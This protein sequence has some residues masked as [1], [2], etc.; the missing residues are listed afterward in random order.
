MI[1]D[2]YQ[3]AYNEEIHALSHSL[4]AIVDDAT[5][6]RFFAKWI[7]GI[8]KDSTPGKILLNKLRH[9][10]K[11]ANKCLPQ[12]FDYDWDATHQAYCI[13]YELIDAKSLEDC[14]SQLSPIY[15]FKGM[16]Q[17][18]SSLSQINQNYDLTHGDI[19]P[20]NVLVDE[21]LNFHLLNLGISDI[22]HTLSEE[23]NI[24]MLAAGF[25]APEKT[26]KSISSGS[27]PFQSDIYSIGKVVEW[28][29]KQKEIE[30][31]EDI[32]AFIGCCCATPE[33][34][35]RYFDLLSAL[36]KINLSVS[37]YNADTVY[38]SQASSQF[39]KELNDSEHLP[40]F[41]VSPKKGGNILMNIA[42]K[43]LIVHCMWLVDERKMHVINQKRVAENTSKYEVTNRYGVKLGLPIKFD[44]A[45][46]LK[47]SDQ[48]DLGPELAKLANSNE[49]DTSY[50]SGKRSIKKELSFYKDLLNKEIEILNRNHFK[51]N[52]SSY[53]VID[54][55]ELHLT[56]NN[57]EKYSSNADI[58][59]HIDRA[60]PPQPEE[61][62]YNLSPKADL[63]QVKR[64]VSISGT[65]YDFDPKN[66]ILKIKDIERLEKGS[67]FNNGFLFEDI[68]K[69]L[70]EKTRQLDA[71]KKVENNEVQNRDLIHYLFNPSELK[72]SFLNVDVLDTVCQTD[73]DGKPFSYSHNQQ[74][75]IINALHREPLTV[76]Q[77]PPGTGKTTV[78]TEIVLQILSSKPDAKILI[79]SQTNDA[80]D[81]V[82]DNL[83]TKEV[84]FVRLSGVN[85]PKQSLRKHTLEKKIDGWKTKVRNKTKTKIKLLQEEFNAGLLQEDLFIGKIFS[86][87]QQDT[88]W[89]KRKTEIEQ[90]IS[91]LPKYKELQKHLSSQDEFIVA[92]QAINNYDLESYMKET[93]LLKGWLDA[94]SSID[95]RSIFNQKLIDTIRVIGATTSHI[96]AKKYK[97]YNFSFDYVIMDESGKAKVSEALIPI[98]MTGKLVFVGDHRQLRPMLTSNR[99]VEK[100]LRSKYTEEGYEY[101]SWE[102]YIDKP[103]LFEQ[104]I[105]VI[106]DDFK[107]QLDVCRRSSAEQIKLTSECF[108]EPYGDEAIRSEERPQVAEHN[109]E[110]NIEGT[111]FFI[112]IGSEYKSRK[113]G[114][115]S[116]FNDQ[117]AEVVKEILSYLDDQERVKGYSVGVITPYKAQVKRINRK[118][119]KLKNMSKGAGLI[120]SVVDKFQGLEKDI[121]IVDLVRSGEKTLGFLSKDNRINVA[122]S[123]QKK[124][125][126]IVG[127]YNGLMNAAKPGKQV[128]ESKPTGL[129]LYLR[130]LPERAILRTPKELFN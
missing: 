11:A 54:D 1:L 68:S 110:L 79:T 124:L 37:F 99:E 111:V 101:D 4:Q 58:A 123:R 102:D 100:W 109:L 126:I 36:K 51:L 87:S 9:H 57:N 91:R 41:N 129:Q 52:Y 17:I 89:E 6:K 73:A 25:A 80:V 67:I 84:P 120:I 130:S 69:E 44:S 12:L 93:E 48:F 14:L 18:A 29:F 88:T 22:V 21:D 28:F 38:I 92:L 50:L 105:E 31:T 23:S 82:L 75:A 60:T 64:P 15:F 107:S 16:E 19:N 94:I 39:I 61:F 47:S 26:N 106:D 72:G 63:K 127:D 45:I 116:S 71:L 74:R 122:F 59:S 7:K 53:Q 90:F 49:K 113:E 117:S 128:D 66:R 70:Q 125:L 32:A 2:K 114:G 119:P 10:K 97:D 46:S 56:I 108:Y 27:F 121:V 76:I 115:G 83:L 8:R 43:S 77:G 42:T 35:Y 86:I 95:D 65:V 40:V 30:V 98:V 34:R 85:P 33:Q 103:S 62:Q 118:L 13:I 78:I 104:V 112:D 3:V 96:A 5:G 81:N 20:A 55:H 24:D